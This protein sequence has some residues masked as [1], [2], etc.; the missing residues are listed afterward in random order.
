MKITEE[1]ETIVRYVTAYKCS[2]CKKE[3]TDIMELQEF[4]TIEFEGGYASVFGDGA[5]GRLDICQHCLKE[6]LGE[7]VEWQE[8]DENGDPV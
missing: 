7:F 2:V 4:S 1:K 5:V 8:Y 3:Y 6:R